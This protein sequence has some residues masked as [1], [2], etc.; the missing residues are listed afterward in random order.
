MLLLVLVVV[1]AF[2]PCLG[3]DFVA[4]DDE[5]NFLKN[6]FFR[7]LGWP[8]LYWDWTSF[9]IGVYQP[10][11]WMLLGAEYLFFGLK[12]W[13][14]HLTN[15]V[16]YA[17]NTVVLLVL[18]I[19]LL[20]RCQTGPDRPAPRAV[21]LGAG[22]AVAL[23]AVHP[24]RT[25]VVVWASCQPHLCCAL[26]EMLAVLAYLY[27]FPEGAAPRRAW[28][29]GAF[30]LFAVALLCKAYAAT[31]PAVLLILDVYPLRRL[32]GGPGRWFGPAV[33]TVWWE[34]I[35]FVVLSLLF[36]GL[37][38]VGREQS[39]YQVSV[40]NAGL[41]ARLAQAC[42]GIGFYPLKTVLP[43]GITAYYP[44][45]DR[46]VWFK[47]PF[48]VGILAT[49][50]TSV[51]LFLWRKRHPGLLAAW[52]SYLVILAPN[53]GLIPIGNYIAAD[54]YSY[55]AMLGLVVL[56]AAGLAR[57][58]QAARRSWAAAA[59][60]SALGVGVFLS[61]IVLSREQCRTWRSTEALWV[62]ALS[63]GASGSAFAH[64]HLGSALDRQ[65][66][67]EKAR[68][69][70]AEALRL[71]PA[72]AEAHSNLGLVLGRQ[73]RLAEAREELTEA[74]RL[75]P[76]FVD[77]LVNAHVNLGVVLS[78]QGE[79]E[80]AQAEFSEAVR[81]K[82][83][84]ADAHFNLG[85]VLIQQGRLEPAG[86]EFSEVL[87]LDPDHADA[88]GNLGVVLLNQGRLDEARAEF[89]EALRLKPSSAEARKNLD[90]VLKAQGRL[91]RGGGRSGADPR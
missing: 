29:A 60:L 30:G 63:H 67:L 53:L 75:K 58:C 33:R 88:H 34:K 22:L 1:A 10:L 35:P 85:L 77:A 8:Q 74:L 86:A 62:H 17:L 27:A 68:R 9:R 81:L 43:W 20:V 70:Y 25:E 11:A 52:L 31:L 16:L 54:R 23:F 90:L 12:P 48:V 40:Q 21:I 37:A 55:I 64:N 66:R 2:G 65:G 72:Y 41:A 18:T 19:A 78:L 44:V 3:N 51:G 56:V 84:S 91:D 42:Y 46:I 61:L 28:L 87:R 14:Y 7:G 69:E 73:G 24:L 47:P 80:A 59:A 57:I 50:G 83:E 36:M 5:A 45:P 38:I 4:W 82:P 26:F 89:S 71:N 13:G 49:L 6:P 15:L 39:R 76:T 32:G 79:R